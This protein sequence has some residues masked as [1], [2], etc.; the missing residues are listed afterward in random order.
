[1]D[2]ILKSNIGRKRSIDNDNISSSS[3][4]SDTTTTTTTTTTTSTV[5]MDDTIEM[6]DENGILYKRES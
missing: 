4:I 6:I 3:S 5:M 1:M 2:S